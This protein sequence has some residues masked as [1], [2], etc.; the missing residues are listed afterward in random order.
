M[1]ALSAHRHPPIAPLPM[2]LA[3]SASR[4]SQTMRAEQASAP[5]AP[6]VPKPERPRFKGAAAAWRPVA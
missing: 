3:N 4:P 1:Q 5:T 2:F 6:N